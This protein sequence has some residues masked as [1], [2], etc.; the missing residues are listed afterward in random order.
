MYPRTRIQTTTQLTLSVPWPLRWLIATGE[1]GPGPMVGSFGFAFA[2]HREGRELVGPLLSTLKPAI[3]G[4]VAGITLR[5]SDHCQW[6]RYALATLCAVHGLMALA[7]ATHRVAVLNAP[8][9][10]SLSFVAGVAFTLK[11]QGVSD[12]VVGSVVMAGVIINLGGVTIAVASHVVHL[13]TAKKIRRATAATG[14]TEVPLLSAPQRD[15]GEGVSND[16]MNTWQSSN[17]LAAA[18]PPQRCPK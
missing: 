1:W 2:G 12:D 13:W 3:L 9:S 7:L 17:P 6:R 8:L 16:Q 11:A 18:V 14:T 4:V 5:E 15:D 10:L